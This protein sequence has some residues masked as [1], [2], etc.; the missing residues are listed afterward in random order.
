M[1]RY[2]RRTD[3]IEIRRKLNDLQ[4]HTMIKKILADVLTDMTVC[5]LEGWD[6][7]E[8]PQMIY[9]EMKRILEKSK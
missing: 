1:Y 5:R 6:I 9:D 2:D 7:Y 3:T 4:R 8:Y